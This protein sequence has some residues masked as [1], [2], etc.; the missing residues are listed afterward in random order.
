MPS[1]SKQQVIDQLIDNNIKLQ[2]K[3]VDLISS[4]SKLTKRI[5]T[6]VE[7]FEEASKNIKTE[8][9]EPLMRK[10]ENLIDQNRNIARGLILLEKYVKEKSSFSSFP[11]KPLPQ[12]NL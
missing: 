12:S 9:S 7:I 11:P 8:S 1:A 5:D 3:M 4:I 2:E 10:L 6:M